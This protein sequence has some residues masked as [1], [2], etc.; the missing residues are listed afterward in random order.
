MEGSEGESLFIVCSMESETLAGSMQ[1][2]GVSILG[3]KAGF[4]RKNESN[5]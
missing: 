1:H 5:A 4:A 2:A 3:R